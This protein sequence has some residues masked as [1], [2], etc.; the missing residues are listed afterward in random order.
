M[1]SAVFYDSLRHYSLTITK[2]LSGADNDREHSKW[3]GQI[4]LSTSGVCTTVSGKVSD[5]YFLGEITSDPSLLYEKRTILITEGTRR[6][7]GVSHSK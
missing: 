7:D 2:E 6:A 1:V 3:S 4:G 5:Y